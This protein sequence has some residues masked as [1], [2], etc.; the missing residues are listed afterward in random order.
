MNNPFVIQ[1]AEA[2]ARRLMTEADTH[3]ERFSKAFLL[4]YARPATNEEIE[5]TKAF[6]QNFLIAAGTD[7]QNRDK[8]NNLAFVSFC[9]SLLI[10]AEFRYLN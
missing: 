9:Q 5:A 6:M 8:V 7:S 4:C 2:M 10:S 1:Q 3:R